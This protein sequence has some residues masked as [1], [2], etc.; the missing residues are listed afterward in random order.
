MLICI[1]QTF[2]VI[3]AS[4]VFKFQNMVTDNIIEQTFDVN[5]YKKSNTTM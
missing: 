2:D 1:K 4:N 3:S 5:M